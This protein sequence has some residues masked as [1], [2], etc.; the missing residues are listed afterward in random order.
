MDV[1]GAAAWTRQPTE[2]PD[3]SHAPPHRWFPAGK[4]NTSFSR[5]CR[6]SR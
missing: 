4:L 1:P 6:N 2:A 3:S 5:R